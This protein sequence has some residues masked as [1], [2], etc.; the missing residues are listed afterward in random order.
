MFL[1]QDL[2][3]E[4]LSL[5]D[6]PDNSSHSGYVVR[7]P[8]RVIIFRLHMWCN[9]HIYKNHKDF[10][11]HVVYVFSTVWVRPAQL[12][13]NIAATFDLSTTSGLFSSHM[14]KDIG[15]M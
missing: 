15:I 12:P 11:K 5:T 8:G 7:R 1:L 14:D 2:R 4:E 6:S 3:F 13:V 9:D 10:I